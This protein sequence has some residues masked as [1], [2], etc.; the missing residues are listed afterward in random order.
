MRST[1]VRTGTFKFGKKLADNLTLVSL[2]EDIEIDIEYRP[3][4][5][6][7]VASSFS[8]DLL[9]LEFETKNDRDEKNLKN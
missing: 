7:F 8:E 2:E 6:K 4:E 3:F 1:L 9:K 5:M